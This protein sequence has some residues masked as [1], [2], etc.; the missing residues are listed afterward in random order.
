MRGVPGPG[1]VPAALGERGSCGELKWIRS[2]HL[3]T[4]RLRGDPA[5][6][7]ARS[8]GSGVG[9]VPQHLPLY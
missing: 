6:L 5:C 3:R 4:S 7:G 8:R 9:A 1:R 2:L